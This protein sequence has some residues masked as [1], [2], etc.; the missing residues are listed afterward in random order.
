MSDQKYMK[1]IWTGADPLSVGHIPWKIEL[2]LMRVEMSSL[3][4][5]LS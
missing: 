2:W 4:D 1:E 3:K 5:D